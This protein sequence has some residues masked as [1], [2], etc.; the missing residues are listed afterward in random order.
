MGKLVKVFKAIGRFVNRAVIDMAADRPGRGMATTQERVGGQDWTD[1]LPPLLN[2]PHF[3]E[4][5]EV[6]CLK[7]GHGTL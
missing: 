5:A 2:L 6:S 3:K 4:Q 1:D 7:G